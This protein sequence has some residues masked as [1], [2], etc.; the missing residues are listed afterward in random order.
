MSQS[1]LE[2]ASILVYK[3]TNP[4]ESEAIDPTISV[5]S[6]LDDLLLHRKAGLDHIPCYLA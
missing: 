2:L 4:E 1:K 6:R 3:V 5:S